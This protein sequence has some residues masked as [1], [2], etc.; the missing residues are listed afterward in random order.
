[1]SLEAGCRPKMPTAAF[2][3]KKKN[4]FVFTNLPTELFYPLQIEKNI[5]FALKSLH[6]WLQK[7]KTFCC[8]LLSK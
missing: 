8:R 3:L 1:M 7:K 5:S 2:S 6:H 4:I